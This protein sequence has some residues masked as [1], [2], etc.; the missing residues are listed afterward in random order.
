MQKLSGFKRKLI[1]LK[2]NVLPSGKRTALLK[3]ENI[4]AG[5]GENCRYGTRHLPAEPYL[6][7]IH[8]NVTIASNVTFCT[9]DVIDSCFIGCPQYASEKNNFHF[10]MGTIEIFDN[11][12]IGA[13][14]TLLYNI[15]IGPNAI[16]GAGSVVTKDVPAGTIVAGN[17]A[18]IIGSFDDLARRRIA[19]ASRATN[20]DSIEKIMKDYWSEDTC[21]EKTLDGGNP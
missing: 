11:V 19:A 3:K 4:F 12:M 6:V 20:N 21:S 2:L 16:I 14:S 1:M 17:P 18:K 5:F 9:H 15:K 8:N 13:N 10:T 7:K